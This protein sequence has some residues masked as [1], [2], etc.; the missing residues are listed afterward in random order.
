MLEKEKKVA[1]KKKATEVKKKDYLVED[2][3]ECIVLIA[4]DQK[5]IMKGMRDYGDNQVLVEPFQDRGTL[6]WK[7]R[8]YK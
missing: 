3:G 1:T 2:Q 8:L 7:A 4:N 6:Q 5:G